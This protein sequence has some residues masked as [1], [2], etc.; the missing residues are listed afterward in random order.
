MTKPTV[1]VDV[2][3]VLASWKDGYSNVMIIGDPIEGAVEFT[4]RLGVSYVVVIHT[5]RCNKQVCRKY[6][7]SL[8]ANIVRE[9]LDRHGFHY[10]D[11]FCGEGKPPAA[12]YIDDRA[13]VCRPEENK[14]AFEYALRD[15]QMLAPSWVNF[16]SSENHNS[17]K[18]TQ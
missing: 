17:G 9:W 5:S 3:G 15:C 16:C 13:V 2:D 1:C 7:P 11:V 4:K 14:V 18:V 6:A 10:D 12:A 8:I